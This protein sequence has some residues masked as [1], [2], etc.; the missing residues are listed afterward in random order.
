MVALCCTRRSVTACTWCARG[1]QCHTHSVT[2]RQY[3]TYTMSHIVTHNVTHCHTVPAGFWMPVVTSCTLR[4]VTACTWCARGGSVTHTGCHTQCHRQN[5]TLSQCHTQCHTSSHCPRRFQDDG[6]YVLYPQIG[7]RLY[8]V[9]PRGSV[10]HTGC[11]THTVTVSHPQDVTQCHTQDVTHTGC[12][13][14]SVT[15]RILRTVTV[16]QCHTQCPHVTWFAQGAV[17]H[18]QDVTRTV[19]HAQC[20]TQDIAQCHS[21]TH[22]VPMSPQVPGRRWL[23]A[24]PA[25]RPGGAG[26]EYYKLYLVGGA[27]ARRCQVQAP[28]GPAP[29]GPAPTLLLTCDRPQRDVRFTIKFQ[30]FSPNLWGHEFRRQHDY[31]IITTSDGTPEGLENGQGGACLTRAMRV[32]LRVGQRPGAEPPPTRT[33]LRCCHGNGPG[34]PCRDVTAEL[35]NQSAARPLLLRGGRGSRDPEG[36]AGGPRARGHVIPRPPPRWR[37]LAAEWACPSAGRGARWACPLHIWACL[38]RALPP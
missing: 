8:L 35:A 24:V 6:G 7:D 26:Y 9:C 2:H 34:A 11:H 3:H 37:G 20:H 12:H 1:G 17:S 28:P 4:S 38:A 14:H 33:Q 25:D 30:E 15:H 5:V 22:S 10:T 19:S 18:T 27:Q 21:V 32:T 16:S 23:R 31:Y 29:P 36:E 13:T